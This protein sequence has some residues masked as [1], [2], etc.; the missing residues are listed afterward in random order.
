MW[1]DAVSASWLS[2]PFSELILKPEGYAAHHR[3]QALE[4][5]FYSDLAMEINTQLIILTTLSLWQP[6]PRN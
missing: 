3:S 6:S 2:L 5:H 4:L 1:R